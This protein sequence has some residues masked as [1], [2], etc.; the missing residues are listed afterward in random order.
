MNEHIKNAQMAFDESAKEPTANRLVTINGITYSD[1]VG[2][3]Q[4]LDLKLEDLLY[5]DELLDGMRVLTASYLQRYHTDAEE[6]TSRILVSNRWCVV[7]KLRDGTST[8]L[9]FVGVYDDGSKHVRHSANDT[10]WIVK[11]DSI[12]VVEQPVREVR[13]NVR[14][15]GFPRVALADPEPK[16]VVIRSAPGH[17]E[18]GNDLEPHGGWAEP[19]HTPNKIVGVFETS[20]PADP[21]S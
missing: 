11:K 13:P 19:P 6:P 8:D 10:G 21:I 1:I 9:T 15:A 18:M 16:P 12:P 5:G 3:S 14:F 2:V 7:E 17:D 20:E 4:P